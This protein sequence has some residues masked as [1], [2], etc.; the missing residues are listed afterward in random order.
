MSVV[1]II[2]AD[3][4]G[5]TT[6]AV[7]LVERLEADGFRA[8]YVRANYFLINLAVR[9]HLSELGY[10]S[11]RK[12]RVQGGENS[13]WKILPVRIILAALGY[14]YCAL[15]HLSMAIAARNKIIVC[16][17]YFY[18]L[19]YDL[20]GNS[21]YRIM[22]FLPRAEHVFLLEMSEG[23]IYSRMV[24]SFDR[25]APAAYYERVIHLM[26][27]LSKDRNFC[28]I[29][30][31]LPEKAISDIIFNNVTVHIKSLKKVEVSVK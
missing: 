2:G 18:Q 12:N 28:V 10:F 16:D 4:S 5:K 3:G 31:S 11:P 21:I 20:F 14:F 17:R 13:R 1:A 26:R 30:A 23:I 8:E 6:Q 7:N 27:E 25:N 29:D 24:S 19:L 9:K 22:N 15:S